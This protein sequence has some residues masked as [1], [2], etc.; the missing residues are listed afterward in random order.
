MTRYARTHTAEFSSAERENW[1]A[2]YAR[3]PLDE[4]AFNTSLETVVMSDIS[5]LLGYC[6]SHTSATAANI[7]GVDAMDHLENPMSLSTES[8]VPNELDANCTKHDR[9]RAL[10]EQW[11]RTTSSSPP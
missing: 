11:P 1:E 5:S 9:K 4:V 6:A 2:L 8:S 7:A 3:V 10:Q